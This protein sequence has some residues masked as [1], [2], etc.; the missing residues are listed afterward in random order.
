MPD[1]VAVDRAYA[2]RGLAVLGATVNDLPRDSRRF[3]NEMGLPYPS[4]VA[5]PAMLEAWEI[6]PWL[7]TTVLV[8]DGK[9][10]R[11][12]VG[13]QTRRQ[14]EYPIKVALGLAPPVS[15]VTTPGAS[16]E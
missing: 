15:A 2:D 10:V 6:A 4:V 16:G 5:T 11:E 9:V 8:K 12:W 14:F 13:P 3:A 7:P 1:L